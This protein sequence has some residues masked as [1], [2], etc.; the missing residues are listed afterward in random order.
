MRGANRI[1]KTGIFS[2]LLV[3]GLVD[4]GGLFCH[5][6]FVFGV[7]AVRTWIVDISFD[8]QKEPTTT[9]TTKKKNIWMYLRLNRIRDD[10]RSSR[11]IFVACKLQFYAILFISLSSSREIY[12]LSN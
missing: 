7:K 4:F 9:T 3:R 11:R 12:K 6:A 1:I 2:L 8:P 5:V 10:S